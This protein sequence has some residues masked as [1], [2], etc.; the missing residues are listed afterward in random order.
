MT[1]NTT[2]CKL[3]CASGSAYYVGLDGKFHPP[4]PADSN[5]KEYANAGFLSP[6]KAY[7][8]SKTKTLEKINAAILAETNFGYVLAFRGTLPPTH[9]NPATL[10]DWWQ[11][12][13]KVDEVD[14]PV[15]PGKV[16]QGFIT[17][18]HSIWPQIKIDL[19][20]IYGGKRI[21]KQLYIT[22]HSKGGPMATYAAYYAK[23]L[24]YNL[25]GV[26][27][28]ASPYPGNA[29]FAKGYNKVIDQIRYENYL[30]IVPWLPPNKEI[31]DHLIPFL[32]ELIDGLEHIGF[33]KELEKFKRFLN[34]SLKLNYT[35]V[36]TLQYIKKNGDIIGDSKNLT[37]IRIATFIAL[38]IEDISDELSALKTIGNAHRIACGGGYESG[39]C[40]I[41]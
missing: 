10:E 40:G 12:I 26:M 36:G 28:F 20:K 30:D 2:M 23:K 38:F 37:S 21:K 41:C 17:A 32:D 13:C 3:L 34:K 22:G 14:D 6:P 19:D 33:K 27:T 7:T 25:G 4:S 5:Y 8:N 31:F 15:L 1:G 24:K 11:D 18:F 35:P 39:V 9:W 16:H 29:V